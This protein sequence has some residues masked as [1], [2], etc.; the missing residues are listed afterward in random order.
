M[1]SREKLLHACAESDSYTTT[2]HYLR[3]QTTIHDTKYLSLYNKRARKLASFDIPTRVNIH[4]Y[5]CNNRISFLKSKSFIRKRV[6]KYRLFL[7]KNHVNVGG[8]GTE[9]SAK[10]VFC[11]YPNLYR[12]KIIKI[13]SKRKVE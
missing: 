6:L 10:Y 12:L 11:K 3:L 1:T 2:T 13:Y 5:Q 7:C 9:T 8:N 4:R